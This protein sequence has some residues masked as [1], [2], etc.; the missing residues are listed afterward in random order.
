ML[1]RKMFS[2]LLTACLITTAY[3]QKGIVKGKVL[4]IETDE[5]LVAAT[6]YVNNGAG[7]ITDYDGNFELKLLPGD[8]ELMA[9]YV[10]YKGTSKGIKVIVDQTIEASFSLD[11]ESSLLN[12]A[13]VTSGKFEKP[14]GEVTVSL[15][16]LKPEVIANT[17]KTALDD[18][19][20]KIPGVTV[21]DGQANIR[22]GSGFS[23]GAGSRVLLLVDDIPILQADAGYPNWDDVPIENI[24][25]IEVVKGAASALYG[26]SALN[27]IIN[28]RT[29]FA[30]AEPETRVSTSYTHYFDPKEASLK[31]WDRAPYTSATSISHKRKIGKFDLV[32]GAYYFNEDS[33]NKDT[34]NKFGR[35]NFNT[36]YHLSDRFVFG[37]NANFNKGASGSFFYW[38]TD[39][40]AYLPAPNTSASRK[41]LR[42]NIDPYATFYDKGDNRHKF[43][44]RF[45]SVDNDNDNN[46][47]NQSQLYYGEYQFQKQFPSSNLAITTGVVGMGT[48]VDAELYGDTTFSSRNFAGYVQVEKKFWKRLNVSAGFRY[49]HNLLINPGFDFSGSQAS[50]TVEPSREKESKPVVRFGLNYQL[51]QATYIRASLGQ[52]YRFPTVAEKFIVTDLGGF[53]IIPNPELQSET[54]WSSEIGIKQGFKISSFEGFIDLAGF[55]MNYQNMMEFN[56]NG[57]SFQSTNIGNTEIKGFEVSL[58]ARGNI[59]GLPVS[60]LTGY[61]YIDPR[62][63]EFDTSNPPAGEQKTIGQI[64]ANNSSIDENILK[65][66][67]RHTFKLDL[68]A[69]YKFLT[70]GV[71]SFHNSHIEAID[72]FFN[73]FVGGLRKFREENNNGY[74][75]HNFRVAVEVIEDLRISLLLGNAFNRKYSI[76]PALLEGPR[77]LSARVD[78]KF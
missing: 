15:E 55:V 2:F 76:R 56:I 17:N 6:V 48:N 77:N 19:L 39:T 20:Q 10:G 37:V 34:Y 42:F 69:N 67:S 28:V 64:N 16:V 61:T 43:M 36:R 25:Q 54:G 9:S 7:T 29:A 18:V 73:V 45:Y 65:Y 30:K 60:L 58:A 3:S 14:L 38:K 74:T 13:T 5:P 26:S 1:S 71:E 66:R 50:G 4:D 24:A 27:G 57:G 8:Y 44:G 49:E 35:I 47:S 23:Q 22:G 53:D 62:F 11:V 63:V 46:Q 78:Y 40:L 31:W 32:A 70:F 51:Y 12:T 41:R 68:E 75:L 52:G 33:Y 59:L 21:M 72:N